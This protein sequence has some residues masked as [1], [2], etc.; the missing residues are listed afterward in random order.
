M[1]PEW[2][3]S[4]VLRHGNDDQVAYLDPAELESVERFDRW[5]F[6]W[7][8][9]QH[10]RA[11]RHRRRARRRACTR[12]GAV[13]GPPRRARGRRRAALGRRRLSDGARC[14]DR[15]HGHRCLGALRLLGAAAGRAGPGRRL[16]R[17][18]RAPRPPDRAARGR[19]RVARHGRRHRPA[20][21][22]GGARLGVLR[23]RGEPARRRGLL[24][25]RPGRGRGRDHV[26]R[27][28]AAQWPRMPRRAP[29]LRRGRRRRGVGGLR[30]G[31]APVAARHRRGRAPRWASSRSARTR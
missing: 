1:S 5:L 9:R 7:A 6:V 27:A 11:R 12:A 23:R 28:V 16:A 22:R 24:R 8:R 14:A 29:A 30:R 17:A 3:L 15:P 18:E 31:R 25:A 13:D 21:R 4:D 10:G 20:H 2:A 19:A 26:R